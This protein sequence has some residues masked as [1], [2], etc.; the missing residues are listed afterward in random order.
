MNRLCLCAE[1]PF[2][3]ELKRKKN[4]IYLLLFV[5]L[6]AVTR[7]LLFPRS[8]VARAPLLLRS[9]QVYLCADDFFRFFPFSFF[10]PPRQNLIARVFAHDNNICN[11][12]GFLSGFCVISVSFWYQIFVIR[13]GWTFGFYNN[14][15]GDYRSQGLGP[16][17]LLF[18]L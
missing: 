16:I 10:V 7:A 14:T 9:F 8:A 17:W 18:N 12:I 4:T 3:I 6:S 15:A 11:E 2:L 5:L 1:S 13:F